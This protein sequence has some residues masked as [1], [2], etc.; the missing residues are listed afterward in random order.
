MRATVVVDN[1]G[2]DGLKGEWGLCIY[3]EYGGKKILLDAGST[4]L[5]AENGE[6]LEIPLKEIDY[7]VLSHAHYDHAGGIRRFFQI[8]DKAK[9]YLRDA[10]AENCYKKIW[11]LK[12]YIGLPKGL[13]EEYKDRIVYASG[14][15]KI[16]EGIS[17][18]PHKTQGLS[19]AGRRESMY[20]KDRQG[21]W[22]P[23]DFSHEQSLVFDTPDGLVIFN[24]CS[25][26]GAANIIRET[27]DT[28][29][30]KKV[31][32]LVGGFHL[33]NKSEE[34]VR[35][36]AGEIKN[37]GI[38]HIYTGHC[39]GKVAYA[40]LKEELGDIVGQLRVGLTMVF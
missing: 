15:Y 20:V 31:L 21:G 8:N 14:D 25:H 26:G 11:L 28:F 30:D 38:R 34:E 13:L 1:I 22:Q 5:F 4:G 19:A 16:A 24:S 7:A 3:V 10:C 12:K 17:L 6:K 27:A 18:I 35:E 36:L 29:P 40:V 37:T 39:T 33:F 2:N 32:A 23:D 9:F